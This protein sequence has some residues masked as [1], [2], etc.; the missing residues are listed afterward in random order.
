MAAKGLIEEYIFVNNLNK[1]A[2]NHLPL[3]HLVDDD[4]AYLKYKN[5]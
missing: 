4:S 2:N 1:E 5:N 3:Q